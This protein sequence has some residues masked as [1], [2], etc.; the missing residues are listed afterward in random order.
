MIFNYFYCVSAFLLCSSALSDE[1]EN[2]KFVEF[3]IS[4]DGDYIDLNGSKCCFILFTTSHT[5]S[6]INS[7]QKMKFLLEKYWK[8]LLKCEGNFFKTITWINQS[9]PNYGIRVSVLVREPS[10]LKG[11]VL[12]RGF[13]GLHAIFSAYN[14]RRS[15]RANLPSA[16]D[17]IK[18]QNN[19]W[20]DTGAILL[21]MKW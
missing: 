11:E 21:K 20:F 19:L 16:V 3:V 15:F 6:Q 18:Y 2:E 13:Q 5:S 17:A 14:K 7:I 8:T 12:N 10:I 4:P 1:I 9:L